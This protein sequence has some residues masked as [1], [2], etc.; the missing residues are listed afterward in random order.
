MLKLPNQVFFGV[1]PA[2]E[3]NRVVD[4]IKH[5]NFEKV[6]IPCAGRFAIAEAVVEAGIEPEN[7]I[8]GD[9][10]LFS[11]AVGG[12]LAGNNLNLLGVE[13]EY[14]FID[15]RAEPIDF[16]ANLLYGM[17]LTKL[18]TNS[19]YISEFKRAIQY[20]M[21]NHIDTIKQNLWDL[22]DTLAGISYDIVDMMELVN[23]HRDNKEVFIFVDPPS[24]GP[25]GY[26]KMFDYGD[27]ITWD[28]PEFEQFGTEDDMAHLFNTLGKAN[29]EAMILRFKSKNGTTPDWMIHHIS[30]DTKMNK[31]FLFFNRLGGE[32]HISRPR[33]P[34]HNPLNLL[35]INKN[36]VIS[37]D[38]VIEIIHVDRD[39]AWYYR[40][41]FSH[42]FGVGSAD[43]NCIVLVDSK[44][45]SVRGY[46]PIQLTGGGDLHEIYGITYNNT[47][48]KH[49]NRLVLRC[50]TSEQ[51]TKGLEGIFEI[52][53]ITT[54]SYKKHR[55]AREFK[56]IGFEEYEAEESKEQ[57]G[58]YKL[59]H[60]ANITKTTFKQHLLN[61]LKEE[62]DYVK[63]R[64]PKKERSTKERRSSSR[65]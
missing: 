42:K 19:Y 45:I 27:S 2:P 59:K 12:Y 34:A 48:Y 30:I 41:L 11:S 16:V 52:T 60:R 51:F 24:L 31:K 56:G 8:C 6:I 5:N 26:S 32:T 9:I 54:T 44:I 64:K 10:S 7:I 53:G 39:V 49:L 3:R 62:E 55:D 40:D 46:A 38:S 37:K 15:P 33:N 47:N 14:D 63:P 36:D 22:H 35:I 50:I 13:T 29:A 61:W 20:E 1:P 17:E 43:I 25:S 21:E 28:G 4:F 65:K 23:V 18:P 58:N 57:I